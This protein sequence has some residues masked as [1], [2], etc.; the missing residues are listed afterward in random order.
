MQGPSKAREG[1]KKAVSVQDTETL[2]GACTLPTSLAPSAIQPLMVLFSDVICSSLIK[3]QVIEMVFLCK[4]LLY[5]ELA[6]AAGSSNLCSK[7]LKKKCKRDQ[8][9][10]TLKKG[11]FKNE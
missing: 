9:I 10:I 8:R 4:S 11:A 1:V 6:H 7:E 5:N 3:C 2:R